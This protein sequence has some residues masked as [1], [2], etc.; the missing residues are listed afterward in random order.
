M[1]V[2]GFSAIAI[3][4]NSGFSARK[5]G[6]VTRPAGLCCAQEYPGATVPPL[7]A[8]Q[9]ELRYDSVSSLATRRGVSFSCC[10]SVP[11]L[12]FSSG[13]A[14]VLG[15]RSMLKPMTTPES[16]T[17]AYTTLSAGA[18]VP[19]SAPSARLVKASSAWPLPSWPR[20]SA[21]P[22]CV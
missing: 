18:A 8:P 19:S 3:C 12:A 6:S 4:R 15:W 1:S 20:A 13:E 10:T 16:A 9:G 2:L 22:S 21:S 11:A 17:G 5:S 14:P 7:T